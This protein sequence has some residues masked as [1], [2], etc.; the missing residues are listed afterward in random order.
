MITDIEATID[1]IVVLSDHPISIVII[2]VGEADFSE[3]TVLDAD[4]SPLYSKMLDRY[5]SR[6]IV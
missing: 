4:E 2:G 1:Q 6:D 5:A 3:M